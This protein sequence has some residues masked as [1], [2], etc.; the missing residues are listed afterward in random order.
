M[1]NHTIPITELKKSYSKLLSTIEQKNNSFVLES[2]KNDIDYLT[3]KIKKEIYDIE[4]NDYPLTKQEYIDTKLQPAVLLFA[5]TYSSHLSDEYDSNH[6]LS[7]LS[8][9]T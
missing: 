5:I 1:N 6:S 2:I 4:N 8:E 7:E 9:A 3:F